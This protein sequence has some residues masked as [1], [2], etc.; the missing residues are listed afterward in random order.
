MW[1]EG[2]GQGQHQA[3]VGTG[4]RGVPQA[5]G[6]A[7]IRGMVGYGGAGQQASVFSSPAPLCAP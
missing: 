2:L 6:N 5:R 4:P 7:G 1:E 3:V